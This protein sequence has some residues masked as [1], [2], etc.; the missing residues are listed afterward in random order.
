[1]EQPGVS[2]ERGPDVNRV[3]FHAAA[4]R[5]VTISERWGRIIKTAGIQPE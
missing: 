3:R 5:P 1:M 4:G 2:M